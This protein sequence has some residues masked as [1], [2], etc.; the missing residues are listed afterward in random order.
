MRFF[1]DFR[2]EI[3]YQNENV[4]VLFTQRILC[5]YITVVQSGRNLLHFSVVSSDMLKRL[6]M[7]TEACA[8]KATQKKG[9]KQFIFQFYPFRKKFFFSLS[10]YLVD[11]LCEKHKNIN[12]TMFLIIIDLVWSD[13]IR[14]RF[15]V[16]FKN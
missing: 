11:W 5:W 8:I 16:P 1:G 6:E 15:F 2:I 14:P 13:Q 9:S 4:L 7:A 12:D 10:T 3:V